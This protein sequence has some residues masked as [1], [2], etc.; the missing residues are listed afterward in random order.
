MKKYI[1]TVLQASFSITLVISSIFSITQV[2]Y[3][4]TTTPAFANLQSLVLQLQEQIETL[5]ERIFKLET[6]VAIQKEELK[7]V[8]TELRVSRSLFRGAEGDDVKALQEFL[9]SFPDIYPEGLVTGFFG[10]LTE[11]AVRKFQEKHA[12]ETIGIVGPK[13]L[14]KINE[15][16]SS[17]QSPTPSG[18]ILAISAQPTEITAGTTT[19]IITA[20]PAIPLRNNNEIIGAPIISIESQKFVEGRM[21][22]ITATTGIANF[23]IIQPSGFTYGG[24]V[25]GCPKSYT[26]KLIFSEYNGLSA[27]IKTCSN[28]IYGYQMKLL[29][30]G[31]YFGLAISATSTTEVVT[32]ASSGSTYSSTQSQTTTSSQTQTGSATTSQTTTSTQL[33]TSS[34]T[35]TQPSTSTTTMTTTSSTSSACT[36]LYLKTGKDTAFSNE[37]T[38]F[39][40]GETVYYRYDC[41]PSG[42]KASQVRVQLEKPDGTILTLVTSTNTGTNTLGFGTATFTPG[43][44]KLHLCI[45]DCSYIIVTRSVYLVSS[46]AVPSVPSGLT[47]SSASYSTPSAQVA[48]LKWNGNTTGITEFR[49]FSRP[50]GSAWPTSYDRRGLELLVSTSGGMV[51]VHIGLPGGSSGTYEFKVQACNS[52]GCSV[53]SNTVTLSLS[54]ARLQEV[55]ALAA[56]LLSLRT[57]LEAMLVSLE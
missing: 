29:P 49:V 1:H 25:S 33:Q 22:F 55:N 42:T 3:A 30:T 44:Y 27:N 52:A 6:T 16:Y 24:T 51:E 10:P 35:G 47:A 34:S 14:L 11:A 2:S 23:G 54:T 31:N 38:T 13:T 26:N 53:D 19:T 46:A 40:V 8:K 41:V 15:T 37:T 17:Q 43:T 48:A 32:T 4:Q 57:T 28:F 36:S 9:R 45:N 50:Q 18:T 56:I 39:T 21:L 12:I 20:I 5:Q 7:A